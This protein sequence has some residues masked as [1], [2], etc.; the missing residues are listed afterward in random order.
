MVLEELLARFGLAE[1]ARR[2]GVSVGTIQKWVRRGPSARG[3]VALARIV[4]RLRAAEKAKET[5]RRKREASFRNQVERPPEAEEF[6]DDEDLLPTHPPDQSPET[7]DPDIWQFEKQPI[8][9]GRKR[10]RDTRDFRGHDTWI[11]ID[12]DIE[13]VRAENIL[14]L[15]VD[16]WEK[17]GAS[18][19]YIVLFMF[20]YVPHNPQYKPEHPLFHKQGQW[21]PQTQTIK[22]VKKLDRWSDTLELLDNH[23]RYIFENTMSQRERRVIWLEAIDV[24]TYDHK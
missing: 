5:R 21:I 19:C 7:R 20:R 9:L 8:V 1:L 12:R 2:A 3:E 6:L 11:K 4:T 16:V 23:I 13:N 24:R 18:G 14:D 15:T 22:S 17:S 10:R